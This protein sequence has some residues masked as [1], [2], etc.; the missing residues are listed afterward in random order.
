MAE[1]CGFPRAKH[2][3]LVDASSDAFN[4]VATA[5]RYSSGQKILIG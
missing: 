3:D 4:E 1:L 2:D 5:T